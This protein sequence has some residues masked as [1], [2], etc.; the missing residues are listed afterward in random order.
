MARGTRTRK[1]DANAATAGHALGEY[2]KEHKEGGRR[3]GEGVYS[4]LTPRR[5]E[6]G[7]ERHA[8]RTGHHRRLQQREREEGGVQLQ[9]FPRSGYGLHFGSWRY[10]VFYAAQ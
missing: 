1:A 2:E 5:I 3:R 7:E 9:H 10:G 4:E 6:E 8:V